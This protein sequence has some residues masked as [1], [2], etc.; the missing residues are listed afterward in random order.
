MM[1]DLL[2]Y[3]HQQILQHAGTSSPTEGPLMDS[4][5]LKSDLHRILN[6]PLQSSGASS[7]PKSSSPEPLLKGLF[8]VNGLDGG[9]EL[10]TGLRWINRH[11]RRFRSSRRSKI[12]FVSEIQDYASHAEVPG[13]TERVV[14]LES[15]D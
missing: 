6:A 10:G 5:P 4:L 2:A 9:A 3:G 12:N 1:P 7:P 11:D 15:I 14:S 8:S 13:P